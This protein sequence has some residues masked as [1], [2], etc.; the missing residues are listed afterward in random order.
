MKAFLNVFLIIAIAAIMISLG[1]CEPNTTGLI[2]I[3]QSEE[4][5]SSI[6]TSTRNPLHRH[7]IRLPARNVKI[8]CPSG[9]RE[10]AN[11][12]CRKAL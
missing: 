3:Q 6:G 11:G 12:I 9:E 5:A 8:G 2:I 7:F 1:T 4:T 10:D